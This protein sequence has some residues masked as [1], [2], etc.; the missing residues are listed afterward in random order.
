MPYLAYKI[1]L[2][3]AET[4]RTAQA[5]H[6]LSHQCQGMSFYDIGSFWSKRLQP[7]AESLFQSQSASMLSVPNFARDTM[8]RLVEDKY[9]GSLV[10]GLS[11]PTPQPESFEYTPEPVRGR[12]TYKEFKRLQEQGVIV[13]GDLLNMTVRGVISPGLPKSDTNPVDRFV[14]YHSKLFKSQ[15]PLQDSGCWGM[16][17]LDSTDGVYRWVIPGTSA[18]YQVVTSPRNPYL[19]VTASR[20]KAWAVEA[21]HSITSLDPDTGLV[22]SARSEAAAGIMDALTTL[23]EAPETIK[24][25]LDAVRLALTKYLEVRQKIKLLKRNKIGNESLSEAIADLWLQF[26]YAVM[27]NVYTVQDSLEYLNTT[28]SEYYSVRRGQQRSIE[29]PS[30][31]GW[32]PNGP[33]QCVERCFIK[34]RVDTQLTTKF[35]R[36]LDANPVLTVWELV[37]FSFIVDWFLNVGEYVSSLTVPPGTVQ[38]AAMSS[39][40]VKSSV[41]LTNP[42]WVGAAI[43]VD[44][45]LYSARV[46]QPSDHIGLSMGWE[47]TFKRAMDAIALSWKMFRGDFARKR[48]F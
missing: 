8:V 38:E 43:N 39:F 42:S 37:P 48:G 23:A 10:S 11:G 34:H 33:V 13:L 1:N 28:L 3:S 26:R 20:V 12:R 22:T 40:R 5:E 29:L 14:V 27:P 24:S 35:D 30:L 44:L 9:Y 45:N 2:T 32:E 19:P 46:I 4:G 16:K 47:V 7:Q 41:T 18:T 6:G 31:D 25:I 21:A 17:P 15:F 36:L